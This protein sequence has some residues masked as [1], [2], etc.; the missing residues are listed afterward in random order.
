MFS[1]NPK[2]ASFY[3]T[4]KKTNHFNNYQN[5]NFINQNLGNQN[6]NNE[7]NSINNNNS[8]S[9]SVELALITVNLNYPRFKSM[10]MYELETYIKNMTI[11]NAYDNKKYF[12]ALNI[13]LN[14]AKKIQQSLVIK[15]N[16][17]QNEK[18]KIEPK[19]N[20][21]IDFNN[22][23]VIE[24]DEF[25]LDIKSEINKPTPQTNFF[26]KQDFTN[27]TNVSQPK[28]A[29]KQNRNLDLSTFHGN[30]FGVTKITNNNPVSSVRPINRTNENIS[31]F[32]TTINNNDNS[33]YYETATNFASNDFSDNF[34]QRSL[35]T[36]NIIKQG[37]LIQ[38][39]STFASG[40]KRRT[41]NLDV[42]SSN[43][44]LTFQ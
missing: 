23:A 34:S 33:S 7:F 1:N 5:A 12:L 16:I 38:N 30:P 22:V 4:A 17:S 26:I 14:E 3:P 28:F 18:S 36:S 40:G 15:Q 6:L 42:G 31:N 27:Q 10:N 20:N 39:P 13:L 19:I 41:S 43:N 32:N 11:N 35:T 24:P 8:L 29:I 44:Y 9:D 37:S 2:V 25:N 21:S